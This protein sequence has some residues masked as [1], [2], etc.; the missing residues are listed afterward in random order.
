MG[1]TPHDFCQL[2]EGYVLFEDAGIPAVGLIP[3]RDMPQ[4]KSKLLPN[5]L[6]WLRGKGVKVRR[7]TARAGDL[8]PTQQEVCP[9]KVDIITRKGKEKTVIVSADN[10]VLDGHHHWAAAWLRSFTAQV[11]IVRVD[12]PIKRLLRMAAA[13]PMVGYKEFGESLIH[14]KS[15]A[16][17]LLESP[18]MQ[19]R[20]MSYCA[21]ENTGPKGPLGA[22]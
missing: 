10:H 1:L 13:F 14:M 15:L 16:D 8:R 19:E 3:R 5:F 17:R 7:G 6:E 9:E 4:I 20:S 2:L 22:K 11:P 21:F 12:L 18:V